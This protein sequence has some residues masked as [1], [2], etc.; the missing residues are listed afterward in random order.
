MTNHRIESALG[1]WLRRGMFAIALALAACGGGG[2]NGNG[3]SNAAGAG[4]AGGSANGNPSQPQSLAA[5]A[6]PVTVAHGVAGAPNVP[7]VSVTVCA[8]GTSTCQTIDNI[9]VD[10]GSF[11]L[12]LVSS[13]LS[14]SLAAALPVST[15][16][17]GPL[18][19]CAEFADSTMWG[20]V[21]TADVKL[22]GETASAIPVQVVGDLPSSIPQACQNL[23]TSVSTPDTVGAN[24]LLGIGVAPADCP[25]CS[26]SSTMYYACTNGANCVPTAVGASQQVANPVA[27]FA[28]DN[29]GVILQLPAVGATG[30]PTVTGTL[31]FGV[32]TQPNNAFSASQKLATSSYGDVVATFNGAQTGAVLDSGSNAMFFNDGSIPVCSAYTYFYCPSSTVSLGA[33]LTGMDGASSANVSFDVANATTLFNTGN[34]AFDN[35]AGPSGSPGLDLGLPFFYGRTVFYGYDQR[36]AGGPAPYVGF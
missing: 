22:A 31:T 13:A 33:T 30:A 27:R 12:R 10:T 1:Q 9:Q 11:G 5:N 32:G 25:W 8:P 36:A 29:N 21:R 23:G 26:A 34:L 6:V 35:L 14:P 3:A 4:S 19:E 7:T 16:A 28:S 18:A 15:V 17:G 20:S 2:D 24:G